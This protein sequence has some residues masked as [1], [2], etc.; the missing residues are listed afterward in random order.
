MMANRPGCS[1]TAASASALEPASQLGGWITA[2]STPASSISAIASA[3][4]NDVTWRCAW[5][6]GRPLPQMW[7][8]ASTICMARLPP[9]WLLAPGSLAR[10]ARPSSNDLVG[11]ER[12]QPRRV[13]AEQLR[14]HRP[15]VRAEQRRRAARPV[16]RAVEPEAGADLRQRALALDQPIEQ[17]AGLQHRIGG[18][19]VEPVDR[20]GRHARGAERG[21][22]MVAR[23]SAQHRLDAR[24]DL[25]AA[26]APRGVAAI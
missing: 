7:I 24:D 1:R 6:L 23:L 10:S 12:R 14:Q 21:E 4:L 8:W 13:V 17:A 9:R 3:A 26:V 20:P 22:P 18:D 2:A 19:L 25:G 16:R 15:R 5:L 11:S